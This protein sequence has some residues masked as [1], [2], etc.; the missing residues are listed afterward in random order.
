MTNYSYN[1]IEY[2]KIFQIRKKIGFSLTKWMDFFQKEMNFSK[3]GNGVKFSV[4]WVSKDM[5]FKI[6]F[7]PT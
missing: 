1:A 5:N 4:E 2:R 6:V 3:I 7:F